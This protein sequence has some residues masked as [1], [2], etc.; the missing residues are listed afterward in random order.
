MTDSGGRFR[1]A[2]VGG[3]IAGLATAWYLGREA[4]LR[5]L[6]VDCVVLEK[7]DR[8]GGKVLTETLETEQGPFVVEGGPDSFLA[9]Q[10]P[11][12]V[13]LADEIGLSERLLGTND[14][15]R[16]VF[17]LSHGR[18]LPLP[19]GVFLL[20]PTK[21]APFLRSPLI[22]P[23]G[24]LRMGLDLLIP[25]RHDD[26]DETLGD[27]VA[28]RLGSEALDKI[29]EPLLSGIYSADVGRQSLLA[30]FP[31]FRDMEQQHRS[32][33]LATLA[34]R[35]RARDPSIRSDS[36]EETAA[37]AAPAASAVATRRSMFVSFQKGTSELTDELAGRL[38]SRLRTGWE[39][40]RLA[41]AG[42]GRWRVWLKDAVAGPGIS[43]HVGF[44]GARGGPDD[45]ES[46]VVDAV[47]LAIPAFSA[48]DLLR[49]HSLQAGKILD[50]IR[51]VG[52]GTIS[53]AYRDDA[54]RSSASQQER[55]FG[56]V[57]PAGEKRP[58]NAVTWSSVKF[59]GRAPTGYLLA[60]VFFGGSRSPRSMEMDDQELVAVVARELADIAGLSGQ[61]LFHRIHR[62]ERANPQYDVSHLE[63]VRKIEETLPPGI[64]VTGSAYRGVGLPDCVRQA[65]DTAAQV[66]GA[67]V[68]REDYR[69]RE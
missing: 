19:E 15:A 41:P 17:V 39:A 21:L 10:K 16:R 35:K 57:V 37:S 14:R 60:R 26:D 61:P 52:T 47:V 42:G 64:W 32:L 18:L 69:G 28:R 67:L 33:I 38:G 66:V 40:S 22:S 1:V 27:F 3:G 54:A 13:E 68:A 44:G 24:K 65:R 48:R 36:P 49:P 20:V 23:L 59:P 56:I 12:A 25:R 2:V 7:S 53:L 5:G 51:Y 31:R 29:A 4:E 43:A 45:S 46:L 63:R 8:T 58:V 11:W 34:G 9:A 50:S 55:G 6:A 62:W 30:T